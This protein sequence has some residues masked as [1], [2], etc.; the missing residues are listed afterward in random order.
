MAPASAATPSANSE[1]L[2]CR[3]RPDYRLSGKS[4]ENP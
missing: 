2:A 4:S 1:D 3:C